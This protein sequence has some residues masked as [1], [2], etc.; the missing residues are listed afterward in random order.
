MNR[1]GPRWSCPSARLRVTGGAT[2]RPAPNGRRI[3]LRP[4]RPRGMP[5]P[6]P[7]SPSTRMLH[8]LAA[9]LAP[10]A[11]FAFFLRLAPPILE[12]LRARIGPDRM[13]PAGAFAGTLLFFVA[14]IG[15]GVLTA[16]LP[17]WNGVELVL[18]A[19]T[20]VTIAVT[21]QLLR[22]VVQATFEARKTFRIEAG[23]AHRLSSSPSPSPSRSTAPL[24]VVAVRDNV[25]YSTTSPA[26]GYC[27]YTLELEV[28]DGS[29]LQNAYVDKATFERDQAALIERAAYREPALRREGIVPPSTS[30]T[31]SQPASGLALLI[32]PLLVIAT[33]ATLS[34]LGDR[35]HRRKPE[36]SAADLG[37]ITVYGAAYNHRNAPGADSAA[38]PTLDELVEA[39]RLSRDKTLDPWG[40]PYQMRCEGE[41][42]DIR[43]AGPDR[44]FGTRDDE[45]ANPSVF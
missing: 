19:S 28:A 34:R 16:L 11:S 43:S 13:L 36:R 30:A 44:V 18:G 21:L 38:C 22:L 1:S 40:T 39:K 9:L 14:S 26:S 10:F 4:P 31:A 6:L 3:P 17:P 29:R 33:V 35:T 37:G 24:H 12:A 15:G 23:A 27:V 8:I 32:L 25:G 5:P 20:A 41:W 45:I 42:I 7:G 2:W